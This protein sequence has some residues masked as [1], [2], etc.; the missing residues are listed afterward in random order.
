MKLAIDYDD[1][2]T[3]DPGFWKE[4]FASAKSRGHEIFMVTMRHHVDS[5]DADIPPEDIYYT[6]CAAK[7]KYMEDRG[8]EMDVW[9]D[10][11]PKYVENPKVLR[12]EEIKESVDELLEIAR[13]EPFATNTFHSEESN[14]RKGL[15]RLS[16]HSM[17]RTI[18]ALGNAI[19]TS[20]TMPAF[21]LAEI[22]RWLGGTPVEGKQHPTYGAEWLINICTTH[23]S[24][25]V[26]D[27]AI[28]AYADRL[29]VEALPRLK[30]LAE[31]EKVDKL[32]R[33]IDALTE[34]IIENHVADIRATPFG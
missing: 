18:G 3:L 34:S 27:A 16:D 8:F 2:Y 6:N 4:V 28:D 21:V 25:E 32:H 24:E 26:R 12:Y 10:D 33:K 13:N 15:D 9:I 29:G 31:R 19:A 30:K 20:D 23:E 1:T 14:L 5:I 7:R 11:N 17:A 22:I